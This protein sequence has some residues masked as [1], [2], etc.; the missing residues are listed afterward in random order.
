MLPA[1]PPLPQANPQVSN[2]I[3][4]LEPHRVVIAC[5]AWEFACFAYCWAASGRTAGMA[6][7][8]V[9]VVKTMAATSA[10]AGR[11]SAR[12]VSR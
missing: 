5:A 10:G 6:L 8:G 2:L 4:R 9:R 11:S 1:A 3:T 7:F 12:W